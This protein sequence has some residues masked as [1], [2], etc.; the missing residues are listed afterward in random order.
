MQI[1]DVAHVNAGQRR[2]GETP[3]GGLSML[4]WGTR[5]QAL[6]MKCA[7]QSQGACALDALSVSERRE[8]HETF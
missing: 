7:S 6:T 3:L 2:T 8:A 1:P 4:R 5:L